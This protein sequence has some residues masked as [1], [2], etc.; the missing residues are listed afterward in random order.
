M[1]RI[2]L[3]GVFMVA[4]SV[5]L[6][7]QVLSKEEMMKSWQAYMTPGEVHKMLSDY[8]GVWSEEVTM[9][10]DSS[11]PPTKSKAKAT[12]RMIFGGRYQE[13]QHVGTMDGK[14]FEGMSILGYDNAKKM[15]Q[16]TW[17]DN[18]G[19]GIMYMEG[20]WDEGTKTI[21][22]KGTSVNPSN[23]QDMI[24]REEYMIIDNNNHKLA[25]YMT[26]PGQPEM[27][28][29]EIMLKRM[30]KMPSKK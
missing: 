8:N 11:G 3:L 20:T 16:N 26:M 6:T 25:M 27:K 24:V 9:W 13:S 12:N 14:L 10:M 17:I 30:G 21:H 23:G 19:T 18:M 2:I 22:F 1:K 28:S 15:F 7:A 4:Y 5:N 29:M